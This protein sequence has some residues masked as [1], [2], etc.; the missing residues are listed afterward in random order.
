MLRVEAGPESKTI[1]TG[2]PFMREILASR[3]TFPLSLSQARPA[4]KIHLMKSPMESYQIIVDAED[5]ALLNR[6]NLVKFS[7]PQGLVFL[8]DPDKGSQVLRS[9]VGDP[10]A[11]PNTFVDTGQSAMHG[12]NV[13]MAAG[14]NDPVGPHHFLPSFDNDYET[15]GLRPFNLNGL[16]LEFTPNASGGYDLSLPPFTDAPPGTPITFE[17]NIATGGQVNN[18]DGVFFFNPPS[19]F[20]FFGHS[21]GPILSSN[22]FIT[23]SDTDPAPIESQLDSG[24]GLARI[25]GFWHDLDASAGGFVGMSNP[26]PGAICFRWNNVPEFG[27][28]NSNSFSICLFGDGASQPSG[29]IRFSYASVEAPFG[30]V[31]ISPGGIVSALVGGLKLGATAFT[32]FS[33]PLSTEGRTGILAIYPHHA[34]AQAAATNVFWHLNENGHDRTYALGFTETEG[35]M[36]NDNF[37]RGGS[38]SVPILAA[39]GEVFGGLFFNNAFFGTP[40]EGSCCPFTAFGLFTDP[41]F[42]QVDSSFD[43]DVVIHEHTHGLSTR[44]VGS[45]NSL[46][47]GAL[48]EGWSDWYAVSYSDDPVVGEYSTGNP[49]T[50]LRFVAYDSSSPRQLGQFANILGPF[51][52]G[53]GPFFVPEVH[54]DGEIWASLLAD[55][56]TRLLAEGKSPEIVEQLVTEAL[57]ATPPNPSLL[58]ARKGLLIARKQIGGIKKCTLWEVFAS[59][60][61]GKNAATNETPPL[62]LGPGDSYSVF[63]AFNT[64]TR[65]CGG[66]FAKGTIFHKTSFEKA[67]VGDTTAGGWTGTGLWHVSARRHAGRRGTNSFYFGSEASGTYDTGQ[68]ELGTLTSPVLNLSAADHPV[69][70]LRIFISTEQLFPYDTIWVRVSTDGGATY[71]YQRAI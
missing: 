59:R 35:N 33:A 67:S 58:D 51:D 46:Q 50:G 65:K 62:P 66:A 7:Q 68:R 39:S 11:S 60:G 23:W 40:P 16:T 45:L 48:G 25:M 20:T 1:L 24:L 41:P 61:F 53:G 13:V 3:V 37:G 54:A 71:P 47:G 31:G 14:A 18:D 44:L 27:T 10:T 4:W 19:G 36:Q 38:G 49:T 70:Q 34:D 29:T 26:E 42:R 55:V 21:I 22:G 6:T 56:R 12:N 57:A 64:P 17:D 69:L 8:F 43:S 9:F 28:T 52:L 63:Q 30:M 5:G 15:N 2:G 32:D